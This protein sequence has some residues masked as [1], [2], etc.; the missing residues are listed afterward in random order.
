M[1]TSRDRLLGLLNGSVAPTSIATAEWHGLISTARETNLLGSLAARV[2]DTES[3][4]AGNANC[5]LEGAWQLSLRQHRSVRWEAQ[6]IHDALADMHVPVVLLKGAAYVMAGHPNARGR[7]FGDI[8]VLVPQASLGKV[9]VRLMIHGW[10]TGKI[11]TY[12]QRYYRKWM[13]EI[14]PLFHIKRGSVLDL[15]HTILPPTAGHAT[16][17]ERI[18]ERATP[19][20]ELPA[21]RI[22]C[23]EDLIIHSL[24]HLMHEGEVNNCLRDM[25]DIHTLI[26][27]HEKVPG[28]W[29]RMLKFSQEHDLATPVALGLHLAQHFLGT[30]VPEGVA[31]ELDLGRKGRRLAGIYDRALTPKSMPFSGPWD[32]AARFLI[33][34]RAHWLRM[35]P[36]LLVA[37]LS[38][39]AWRQ[40]TER[41]PAPTDV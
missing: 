8:D 5:H 11:D 31:A 39:K 29:D 13:H 19:L 25:F 6:C 18:I 40:M 37:H 34:L 28:F 24:T 16:K 30:A 12:D 21:L 41:E 23:V 27:T 3:A 14:P 7:L 4:P 32:E 38:R 35:P 1:P 26:S 33:Y 36:A 15:H 10:N 9:E 22:P 2:R 17:A 20:P